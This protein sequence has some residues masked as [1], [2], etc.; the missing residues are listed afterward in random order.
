[1]DKEREKSYENYAYFGRKRQDSSLT[2]RGKRR[3]KKDVSNPR[4]FF[5][6]FSLNLLFNIFCFNPYD[7]IVFRNL[8]YH[9]SDREGV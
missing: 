6:D 1:M 2:Q 3:D 4:W 5:N 9:S 7:R 8:F